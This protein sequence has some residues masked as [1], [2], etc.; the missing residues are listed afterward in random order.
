[1]NQKIIIIVVIMLVNVVVWAQQPSSF[2]FIPTNSSGT[3]YG[4]A[5][6][7]NNVASANDWIAAFDASGICAGANQIIINS[8]IAYINLVIYGDDATTPNIDEGMNGNEDFTLKLFQVSS[9]LYLDYPTS[10]SVNNFSNWT[11]T[12]GAPM[13]SYSNVNTIY[14]FTSSSTVSFS[15]NVNLCENEN[16]FLLTGGQ[17][18]GGV[19]SGAGVV[20]GYFDPLIAGAG[21][22]SISYTYN[23]IVA[24]AIIEV[25]QLADAS[26]ITTGP[27]CI[28]DG[29]IPL[30]SV[31][32]G[33]V[34]SGSGIISN[35]FVPNL[36]SAGSY[37]INY[38][39]T[40]TNNCTQDI[41]SLITV[42]PA[43]N[44]PQITQVSNVLSCNLF[45]VSYQWYD[46]NM[47]QINGEIN[48]TFTPT[49]NGEYY[50]EVSNGDCS[51]VSIVF[52]FYV[53]G[54]NQNESSFNLVIL[55]D[56]V[57]V[58]MDMII[59]KINLLNIHGQELN[60]IRNSNEINIQNLSEGF[61]FLIIEI[62]NL[63]ICKKIIL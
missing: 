34:Y 30:L 40:D 9:G 21:A 36:V 3:F 5:Q 56:K 4:Q 60:S 35:S 22:H 49:I 7:N 43:P 41:Q 33:G 42:I 27:F 46:S 38:L 29:P 44:V 8:G 61:Y 52:S 51:E 1:M 15:L 18:I 28:N 39:L 16:P 13:P 53:N 11:N 37:W 62:N 23:S 58:E 48:Q 14:D 17:P 26:L 63:K 47:N 55:N 59:N 32:N 6:I 2:N 20:N 54:V 24:T 50:V 57:I 45:G 25:F 19:Y 12:N 31:T 10:S